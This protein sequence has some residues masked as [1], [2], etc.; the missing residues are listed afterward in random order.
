MQT[1]QQFKQEFAQFEQ[2]VLTLQLNQET[3]NRESVRYKIIKYREKASEYYKLLREYRR[4]EGENAANEIKE[5]QERLQTIRIKINE[6][7]YI[8][9]QLDK[10]TPFDRIRNFATL[11]L[12]YLPFFSFLG[13][14]LLFVYLKQID[15]NDSF[16]TILSE[17]SG[18]IF[19]LVA[20]IW[21]SAFNFLIP[22]YLSFL[23]MNTTESQSIINKIMQN[24]YFFYIWYLLSVF[25]FSCA[26]YIP[27]LH[28]LWLS[29]FPAFSWMIFSFFFHLIFVKVYKLKNH[30]GKILM[31]VILFGLWMANIF[32]VTAAFNTYIDYSNN[33][34][35]RLVDFELFFTAVGFTQPHPYYFKLDESFVKNINNKELSLL[36]KKYPVIMDG[37]ESYHESYLYG[38]IMVDLKDIKILCSVKEENGS[39]FCHRFSG[40]DLQRMDWITDEAPKQA[41]QPAQIPIIRKLLRFLSSCKG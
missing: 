28:P 2:D 17:S 36:R 30:E 38:R 35:S 15:L 22:Y 32:F 3:E 19:L 26:S 6:I 40:S 29:I 25:V 5:L 9:S 39:R 20:A 7:N 8:D 4:L 24:K 31:P 11:L 1:F 41:E 33:K 14:S 27:L 10:K 21:I 16:Y 13:L 23:R 18:I 12:G 37:R 34:N